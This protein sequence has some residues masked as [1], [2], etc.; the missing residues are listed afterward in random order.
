MLVVLTIVG[1]MKEKKVRTKQ[2][3]LGYKA[4]DYIANHTYDEMIR[5]LKGKCSLMAMQA[6]IILKSYVNHIG[7]GVNERAVYK[8]IKEWRLAGKI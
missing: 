5:E 7:H 8:K 1:M 3:E 6:N 4:L 2:K